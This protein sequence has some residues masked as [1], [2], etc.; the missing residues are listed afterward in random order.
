[1]KVFYARAVIDE[2]YG[3]EYLGHKF[4]DFQT[5]KLGRTFIFCTRCNGIIYLNSVSKCISQIIEEIHDL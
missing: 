1:M 4:D 5:D 3:I 2:R